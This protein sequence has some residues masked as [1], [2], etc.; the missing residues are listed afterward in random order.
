M[1][2]K[3]VKFNT[4]STTFYFAYSISHLKE[5]I[6]VK[7]SILLVDENVLAQHQKRFKDW[8]VI[9]VKS[10]EKHKTQSTVN[11]II[12]QLIE[13]NANRK[14]ILIGVGGGVVTDITGYVASI[15]MR[16]IKFGF[17]PTTILAMVDAS[18]GGKNGIDVG[19][20][21]NMVGTINQP[22]F[23]LHD[24]I[25]LNTLP[26]TE[27]PNGFAEIIKHA[28]IKDAAM[29]KELEANNLKQYQSK[30]TLLH[31]L[32]QRNALLKTKVVIKDEFET[33]DRKLLNFGHTFGHAIEN[34]YQLPHGYAVAIGMVMAC[35]ISV[36][37]TNFK[38]TNRV[39]ELIKKYGLPVH[40]SYNA[41][42]I[43]EVM[44][45]DKKKVKD[46]INYVLLK[47]I[48]DAVVEPIPINEVENI[49]K[50]LENKNPLQG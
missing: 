30:K 19:V 38:D 50:Q 8:K 43:L 46:V 35:I 5:I 37:Y 31:N 23:I 34:T 27:W 42:K 3:T 49:I 4:S 26:E 10:G 28:C 41:K 36:S 13:L 40:Q 33:G 47:K 17:V 18:I 29:F 39:V 22:S 15:F 45:A 44:K 20:Y 6:D 1:K 7:Q 16:G 48:G 9:P 25:F 12:K 24:L 2:I 11:A 21:K 14:T 32:I